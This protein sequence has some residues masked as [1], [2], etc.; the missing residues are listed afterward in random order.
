DNLKK[1]QLAAPKH[2]Q[3][4]RVGDVN[5]AVHDELGRIG[6]QHSCIFASAVLVEVLHRVGYPA[7]H[8]LT[9]RALIFNREFVEWEKVYGRPTDP[10][11]L[12]RCQAAGGRMIGLGAGPAEAA[13]PGRWAGHLAV[14]LLNLFGDRHGLSDITV[15]Q[16]D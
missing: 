4:S 6:E 8:P 11:D 12:A 3:A 1:R 14:V 10:V 2:Y 16:A 5:L 7:V 15:T 9:V 13:P